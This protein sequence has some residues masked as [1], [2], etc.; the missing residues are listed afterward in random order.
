M[1]LLIA[2]FG[3]RGKLAAVFGSFGWGGGAVKRTKTRLEQGGF[4]VVDTLEIRGPPK[5]DDLDKAIALGKV[6]AKRVKEKA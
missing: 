1:Q 3:V 5:P 6:V 4:E 2:S